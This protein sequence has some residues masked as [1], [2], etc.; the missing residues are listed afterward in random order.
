MLLNKRMLMFFD[1]SILTE[2]VKKKQIRIAFWL[3]TV[4]IVFVS[5]AFFCFPGIVSGQITNSTATTNQY[6]YTLN[7]A[8]MTSAG[9]FATDST[10]IRTL[11][12]TVYR[13]AGTYNLTWDGKDDSG[14]Q[15]PAGNYIIE[16]LSNNV[17]YTWDGIIGNTSDTK[18]GSTVHRGY[19]YF[20]TGMTIAN[21]TAYYCSGYSEGSPS[22]HKL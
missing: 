21:G 12:T 16:V 9:V 1:K 4:F 3:K 15:M 22:V 13:Q 18:T 2:N 11:W 19:Y 17:K 20:M 14:N 8:A 7:N 10:L 5:I 6:T